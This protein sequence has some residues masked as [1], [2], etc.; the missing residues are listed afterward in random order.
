M[1]EKDG[2]HFY[3]VDGEP[4][5]YVGVTSILGVADKSFALVPW[6]AKSTVEYASRII[7]KCIHH[8][9][10]HERWDHG[11]K[12]ILI[13][14][15]KRQWRFERDKAGDLGTRFHE[16]MEDPTMEVPKDLEIAM[17]SANLWLRN[18]KLRLVKGRTKIISKKYGFGG[19]WD[20]LFTGEGGQLV[21]V[22]FKTGKRL[23][24]SA[25]SQVS[26]YG[27]G[28][29]ETFGIEKMPKGL[30]VRFGKEKIEFEEKEVANMEQSFEYFKACLN[31][32]NRSAIKQFGKSI[33]V[34]GEKNERVKRL[35][36]IETEVC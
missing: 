27:V 28:A 33:T 12:D 22:D 16:L 32:Y 24:E 4:T 11:F 25:A 14:R 36:T 1:E 2:K 17:K 35:R 20:G 7:S 26:A 3:S 10:F 31:L 19:E 5:S 23:Y 21:V 30:I 13:K 9:Y 6:G 29:I 34:K 18:T 15:A 8:Q